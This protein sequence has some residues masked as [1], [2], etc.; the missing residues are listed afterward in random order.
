MSQVMAFTG[1]NVCFSYAQMMRTLFIHDAQ[2]TAARALPK[3]FFFT[4]AIFNVETPG[5][6]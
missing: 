6:L 1:I 3:G 4:V 5:K 2:H